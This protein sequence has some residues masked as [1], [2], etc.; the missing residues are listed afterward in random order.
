VATNKVLIDS[1][2]I[3]DYSRKKSKPNAALYQSLSFQ[4]KKETVKIILFLYFIIFISIVSANNI[5]NNTQDDN[6]DK[7]Q[8]EC[9]RDEIAP[10]HYIDEQ[11]YFQGEPTLVLAGGGKHFA[12]GYWYRVFDIKQ[13]KYV[14]FIAHFLTQNVEEI[15]RS[16]LARIR[17]LTGTG[18][19]IGQAEY[20]ATSREKTHDIWGRIIQ[21]YR[22]PDEAKKAKIELIYRWDADGIV[23]FGGF[24]FQETAKPEERIVR[25]ASIHLRPRKTKSLQ[26]NLDLFAQLIDQAGAK[27]ADIVCLPEAMNK[28]GRNIDYLSASEQVPGPS[29][30]FLGNLARKH[31]MY[32]VA[33]LMERYENVIYNTA[34]LIDRTG[35]LSGKYHKV[36]LPREEI[37]GGVTPG[38][39]LPVF[40]TDFGKIGMMICWDV[41]FPEPA[42]TL[43]QKGAEVIFLPIWGGNLNLTQARANENQIYLVSSTYDMKTAVFDKRGQIIEEATDENPVIVVEVDLNKQRLYPWLG[44]LK[45]RIFREIPTKKAT[46]ID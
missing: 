1:S 29:T 31:K 13:Y 25:L 44:D 26:E 11:L 7:W 42:R 10:V 35:E 2:V 27:K 46:H 22:V 16:V 40:D 3:I 6:S 5:S 39:S 18:K 8:F 30:E 19:Q 4:K 23:H 38:D 33:G 9:K 37:E 28:I 14:Q 17:W 43:T 15:N 32:I 21:Y 12:N 36:S 41:F 24:S 20:P 45:N 34:V